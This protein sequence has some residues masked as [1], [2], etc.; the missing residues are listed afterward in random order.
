MKRIPKAGRQIN[1][2]FEQVIVSSM[3]KKQN[4]QCS[5]HKN[6]FHGKEF[7]GRQEILKSKS[8]DLDYFRVFHATELDCWKSFE[9]KIQRIQ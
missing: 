2:I 3:L 1:G 8:Y 9:I 7:D 6:A 5:T 4:W